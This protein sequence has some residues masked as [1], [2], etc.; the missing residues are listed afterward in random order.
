MDDAPPSYETAITKDHWK[1]IARYI[2]SRDLCS[3]ALVCERWHEIFAP[4][5]WGNPASHFGAQNDTVYVAL[6]RFKRTLSWARLCVRELTHTLHLPPAHAEIYGGPHSDWLRDILERLPRLQ[7]LIVD[8]LPFFDHASLLTLRYSSSYASQPAGFPVYGLRLLDAS[9]CSN[10][11]SNGLAEAL[12]HFPALISLD[13][14]RTIAAR[15]IVV[16]SKLG[17]LSGLRVLKLRGLSLKDGDFEMIAQSIGTRVTSLD[18]RDNNLTDAS[19]RMLL[20]HCLKDDEAG[21]QSRRNQRDDSRYNTFPEADIDNGVEDL[22]R[23]LRIKLTQG[24]VGRLAI[25]DTDDVGITHLHISNNDMTVEGISGLIRSKRLSFLDVGTLSRALR[26][27]RSMSMGDSDEAFSLPGA[28]KL[29]QVL[30]ESGSAGLKHLRINHAVITEESTLTPNSPHRAEMEG[31]FGVYAPTNAHEL[32]AVPPRPPELDALESAVLELPGDSAHPSELPGSLPEHDEVGSEDEISPGIK[33]APTFEVTIDQVLNVRRG[34]AFAPEPVN[35]DDA[36]SPIGTFPDATGGL[37]PVSPIFN[38]RSRSPSLNSLDERPSSIRSGR[39]SIYY[40]EERRARL[41]LRQSRE[42]SLHPGMLPKLH[43]LVLTDVPLKTSRPEVVQRL[44][45][46]IQDCAEETE[47]AKLR[48][49]HTYALP[50]GR[51]RAVAEREYARS[52]F[53]LRRIVLEMAPPLAPLKKISTS[54][55]QYPTKSSTEDTDSEKFWDAAT[56]DFSFFGDEECGLPNQEPGRHLPLAA[57]S[58]LMLAP[59]PA[60]ASSHQSQH[61]LA[62]P[63]IDVVAELSKFRKDRKAA[64]QAAVSRGDI[65][66]AIEGYWPGDITVVRHPI[67]SEA[68]DYYGNQFESGWHYR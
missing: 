38:G 1:I 68:V 50:P 35:T 3:A 13:L 11:T 15:D 37:S 28:E 21:R 52:L 20:D 30:A 63:S 61:T 62:A 10:S 39:N 24:F 19:A 46:F 27:P 7:S 29:T 8:G 23:Y 48:A 65:E 42:N 4:H 57:M 60:P 31:N 36:L 33:R 16:F 59:P 2:R 53:S 44:V 67:S 22:D 9:N 66:P 58:G 17:F 12:I 51:S 18:L 5:L 56:H 64:F 26:R 34:S 49:Q 47:M 40:I 14:S 25:E 54:W 45:Q 55:R 32:E 6:T 43:T 41:E